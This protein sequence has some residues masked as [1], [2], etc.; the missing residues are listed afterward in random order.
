ML[1]THLYYKEKGK[2]KPLIL[3]HGNGEDSSYFESQMDYFFT[4]AAGH[5]GGHEGDT[6]D[7]PGAPRPLPSASSPRISGN[8]WRRWGSR[9]RTFWDFQTG[10]I[11][12]SSLP[13]GIRKGWIVSS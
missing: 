13:C 10:E 2:G 4:D 6:A 3:L 7:R 8:L 1:M 12:R 11:S 9:G 5:R